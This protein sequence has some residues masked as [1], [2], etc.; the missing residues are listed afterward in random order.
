MIAKF[1][2]IVFV[3]MAMNCWF[4]ASR[5]FPDFVLSLTPDGSVGAFDVEEGQTTEIFLY[6]VQTN[7]N[8]S[9]LSTI[10]LYSAGGTISYES[11][12]EPIRAQLASH[13]VNSNPIL[14]F[15]D[16]D[17]VNRSIV[18]E[19][20]NDLTGVF[21]SQPFVVI[22]SVTF[23]SGTVGSMLKLSTSLSGNTV[24]INLLNDPNPSSD[25]NL[26]T[27]TQF[28]GGTLTTITA[29]PEP[30]SLVLGSI[31]VVS[32]LC[33]ANRKRLTGKIKQ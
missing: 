21:A 31:A 16:I 15:V 20:V 17:Q 3:S 29:V 27:P 14:N 6:L 13:W 10:G 26:D 5:A 2:S 8:D 23:N 22:G 1:S 19:G 33:R 9:R 25:P 30:S 28:A 7:G 18:L 12:G 4:M 11:G 32:L 24:L